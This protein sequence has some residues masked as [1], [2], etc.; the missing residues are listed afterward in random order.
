MWRP[1]V[2]ILPSCRR[3][4]SGVMTEDQFTKLFKYMQQEFGA[5]RREIQ[6]TRTELKA[7]IDSVYNVVDV[8]IHQASAA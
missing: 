5:V 2:L 4:M 3:I 6:E 1:Y 7:D 8:A